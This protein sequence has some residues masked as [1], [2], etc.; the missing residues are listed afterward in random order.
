MID[1]NLGDL[2]AESKR[3]VKDSTNFQPNENRS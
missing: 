1:L 2:P 3:E